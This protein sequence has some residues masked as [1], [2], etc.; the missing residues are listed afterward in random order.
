MSFLRTVT[1]SSFQV[2][3][4]FLY[5]IL[6]LKFNMVKYF[7]DEIFVLNKLELWHQIWP[8]LSSNLSELRWVR[9][10]LS[11]FQSTFLHSI[12]IYISPTFYL[13][14][15]DISSSICFLKHCTG[16]S[17][18]S[19]GGTQHITSTTF[20]SS[21]NPIWIFFQL[22]PNVT[23]PSWQPWVYPELLKR[24]W[25]DTLLH[26]VVRGTVKLW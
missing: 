3:L 19:S 7:G 2:S 17:K 22:T 15:I 23:T 14:S 25:T 1:V 20:Y 12:C 6:I 13:H 11:E 10:T 16:F 24:I 5:W 18:P 9:V 21:S 8:R 26:I 4:K